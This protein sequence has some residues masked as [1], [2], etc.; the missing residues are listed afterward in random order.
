[1]SRGRRPNRPDRR[2]ALQPPCFRAPA[3]SPAHHSRRAPT[4]ARGL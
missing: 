2:L 3:R 4:L 1:L